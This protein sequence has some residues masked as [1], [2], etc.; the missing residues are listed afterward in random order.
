MQ[1]DVTRIFRICES[2]E[3]IYI[4][5]DKCILTTQSDDTTSI[6][7]FS[8]YYLLN[9]SSEKNAIVLLS[10]REKFHVP[11]QLFL[12][13]GDFIYLDE[14]SKEVVLLESSDVPDR[15]LFLTGQCNSNCIMCPYT[16]KWR[17]KAK[18]SDFALLKRF[19]D[20][21][22]PY[23]EYVC[24]T[25]GE[26]T[27]LGEGFLTLLSHIKQHFVNPL[28]HILTNGRVFYYPDFVEDYMNV[29]SPNT[30]LGIPIYGHNAQTHDYITQTP[31][32]FL[33]TQ[34]GIQ[35]LLHKKSRIEIRIVVS[36]L[37]AT[38]LLHIGAY[39]IEKLSSVHIVS[40]MGIEMMGS[41]FIHKEI[42]WIDFDELKSALYDLCLMLI[43]NGIQVQ[44]YNF[45]LC[46]LHPS[47]WG[48]AKKSISSN[49]VEYFPI[50][51]TCT[52]KDSC[53]GFFNSTIHMPSV[54]AQPVIGGVEQ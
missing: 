12:Q 1:Y 24:V 36:A 16:H 13:P 21:M 40:I 18:A 41:A 45:P 29:C 5:Q 14:E 27:L 28:V 32:S 48:I 37:N 31:G 38:S 7:G 33:Q 34:E 43:E 26:P 30:L 17:T 4:P 52:V 39:I 20:L 8:G 46:K 23:A 11:S 19:V 10:G 9:T 53:G 6:E 44:L 51:D 22:N 35:N 3:T 42:V 50:C 54:T 2:D 49:K 25:G 47:L 15:V